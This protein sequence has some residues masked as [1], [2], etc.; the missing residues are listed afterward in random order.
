VQI[1]A[2]MVPAVIFFAVLG[3]HLT[4]RVSSALFEKVVYTFI[5][6]AGFLNI[7]RFFT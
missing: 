3:H 2:I 6:L 4:R 1:S 5:G 7:V